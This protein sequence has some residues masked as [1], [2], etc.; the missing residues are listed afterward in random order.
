MCRMLG[1][2]ALVEPATSLASVEVFI[3]FSENRELKNYTNKQTRA[4]IE[5]GSQTNQIA[6]PGF[7]WQSSYVSSR[8]FHKTL[9]SL[10]CKCK[11]GEFVYTSYEAIKKGIGSFKAFHVKR[12]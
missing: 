8:A 10:I 3:N 12:R 2:P 9:C 6:A 1:T 11:L 7:V 4:S 5:S